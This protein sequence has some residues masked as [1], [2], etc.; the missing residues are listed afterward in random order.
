MTFDSK[1]GSIVGNLPADHNAKITLPAAPAKTGYAFAGWYKDEACTVPWNS[2]EDKVTADIM[3]FAKWKNSTAVI[4]S[5]KYSI[6]AKGTSKETIT[7][8]PFGTSKAVFLSGLAKGNPG[9]SWNTSG[10]EDIVSSGNTLVVTAE[11]G[12]TSVTY[13]VTVNIKKPDV[14]VIQ[15][16]KAG[17]RHVEITWSPVPDAAGFNIYMSMLSDTFGADPQAT[18]AAP[19]VPENVRAKAG[20]SRVMLSWEEVE[21]AIEYKIY[22]S[23]ESGEYGAETATVAEAVYGYNAAGLTNGITYYFV[24]KASNTGG[25]SPGSDEVS[26]VPYNPPKEEKDKP[27]VITE[28]K[29]AVPTDKTNGAEIL[30]N[31]KTETAAMATTTQQGNKTVTTY[32]LDDK[33]IEEKLRQAGD[34]VVV[35]VPVKA[36]SDIVISELNGQTM[37]NMENRHAILEIKTETATYTLPAQQI[38]IDSVSAQIGTKV[39]LEDIKVQIEISRPGEEVVDM[40][41]GF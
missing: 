9:Q 36:E 10:I 28:P 14:P 15:S 18:V 38:N 5:D 20:I 35:T 25:D 13:T 8:V 29:P 27:V 37:K 2:A 7:N 11:D 26:A 22:I 19:A 12:A 1:G 21:A 17:N 34:N 23:T 3:I 30:V 33:K 31:W 24:I 41:V 40:Y 39:A 4:T 6:S 32:I 16:S